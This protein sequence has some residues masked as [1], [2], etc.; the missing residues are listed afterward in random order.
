MVLVG[1]RRSGEG[2]DGIAQVDGA[3]DLLEIEVVVLAVRVI[4][5]VAVHVRISIGPEVD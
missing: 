3:D 1:T 5:F 4:V 2:D